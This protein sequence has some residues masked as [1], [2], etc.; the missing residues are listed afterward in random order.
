MNGLGLFATLTFLLATINLTL[1][2]ELNFACG[3]FFVSF[4]SLLDLKGN[5][6][7]FFLFYIILS[8][9]TWREPKEEYLL[10]GVSLTFMNS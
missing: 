3:A 1:E 8:I 10:T 7:I 6:V 5:N 9:K 2:G 4:C